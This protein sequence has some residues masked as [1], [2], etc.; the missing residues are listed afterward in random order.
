MK[1]KQT[2]MELGV[3]FVPPNLDKV[4][5]EASKMGLPTVEAE[6]FW[7]YFGSNGW[8]V[9]RVPMKD[10]K[11]ALHH[12]RLKCTCMNYESPHCRSVREAIDG[13]MDGKHNSELSSGGTAIKKKGPTNRM[14][15]VWRAVV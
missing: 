2:E 8:K 13:A 5:T 14:C 10:W 7:Y 9:G 12:W 3:K 15:T 11:M 4:I 1:P 6:K